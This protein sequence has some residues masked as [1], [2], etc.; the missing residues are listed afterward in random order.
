MTEQKETGD[1]VV[2]FVASST[3]SL[4][5]YT[6]TCYFKT[7]NSKQPKYINFL[8]KKKSTI[9]KDIPSL[10]RLN[11]WINDDGVSKIIM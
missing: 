10:G 1:S 9:F 11:T 5:S 6:L 2:L 4:F 3:A 8:Q 7:F